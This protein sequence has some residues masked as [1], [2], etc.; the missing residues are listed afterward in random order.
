MPSPKSWPHGSVGRRAIGEIVQAGEVA[1]E[2]ADRDADR[3]RQ[4]EARAGAQRNAGAPFVSSIAKMPPASAPSIE[5]AIPG[6]PDSQRFSVP[7]R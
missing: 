6:I 5:R 2:P 7:N 1:A 3:E 4:R